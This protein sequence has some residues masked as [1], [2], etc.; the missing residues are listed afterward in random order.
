MRKIVLTNLVLYLALA[1][2][3]CASAEIL[4]EQRLAVDC[5]SKD[6]KSIKPRSL[7]ISLPNEV[8]F[9]VGNKWVIQGPINARVGKTPFGASDDTGLIV[10][11]SD[12]TILVGQ[13]RVDRRSELL[14]AMPSYAPASQ[15]R[16][17]SL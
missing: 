8:S 12:I 7:K 15:L 9:I 14:R 3:G 17:L 11:T 4:V 13:S 1:G 5:A 10:K 2:T 6:A 16:Y